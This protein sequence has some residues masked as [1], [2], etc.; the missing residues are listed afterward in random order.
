MAY[1]IEETKQKEQKL[2]HD[3]RSTE[4]SADV[5]LN[6]AEIKLSIKHVTEANILRKTA[7]QKSEGSENC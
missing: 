1:K 6:K 7:K 3:L 2:E 4:A 5:L